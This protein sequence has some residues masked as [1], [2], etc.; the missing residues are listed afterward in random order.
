MPETIFHPQDLSKS[1]F[2]V[3]GGAGF[4]GSHIVEYLLKNGAARV[5]VMD[6][7]CTGFIDNVS[8]FKSHPAYEFIQADICDAQQCMDACKGIDYV[9]HQ[10][11]LGSVPRSIKDPMATNLSN[12]NGFLNVLMAAK[13]HNV[14]RLVYASSS[15]V[16]G[17]SQAM[18]KK[19]DQ[20]GNPLS[21]YAVTKRVNELYGHVFSKVYSM[22][23]VGLRYF[24]IFGPR[25]NP[26]GPYAAAIPIFMQALVSGQAPYINGD[27]E[28]SR[29]FTYVDNAVQA[30]VKAMF[31]SDSRAF[32][33]VFNIAVGERITVNELYQYLKTCAGSA[34]EAI[35]RE[36]RAGDVKHSLADISKARE[37]LGYQPH[38]RVLDGLKATFD[39]FVKSQH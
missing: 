17:D 10:A 28:Q 12:V 1:T 11:A 31:C 21:P 39:W 6:N 15:S 4:I 20:L 18:P 16:F 25:Q 34:I 37:I 7:L 14:K 36:D 35:H 5:V 13:F 38:V 19:E 22:E 23:I 33:D 2:L 8:L 30:N 27:G 9:F 3:T 26:A 32:G 29:D 24:N